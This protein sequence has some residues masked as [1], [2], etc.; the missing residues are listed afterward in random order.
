MAHPH[1]LLHSLPGAVLVICDNVLVQANPACLRLLE[2]DSVDQVVG[3]APE[4]FVHPPD[5]TRSVQRT[6]VLR[7]GV[8]DNQPTQMRVRTCKGALRQVLISSAAFRHEGRDAVLVNALDMSL[9]HDMQAQLRESERNFR[10]LFENMQDVYYRTNAEGVVVNVG[11]AVRRVLG[12]EPQDIIGRKAEAWYPN[13]ADRDAFKQAILAQGEVADFPGQMVRSDGRVIDI[14]ISSRALRDGDGQFAGVE[15]LWRD[16]TQRRQ[17]ERELRRMAHTDMLTGIA[18]RRAFLEQAEACLRRFRTEGR[19]FALLMLDLDHF[20]SVNDRFGHHEGDRVL[21]HFAEAVQSRI[22]GADMLG[23]LGGEE[24][25]LLLVRPDADAAE[26]AGQT[27]LRQVQELR[28]PGNGHGGPQGITTSIGMAGVQ[29]G[30]Q[31]VNDLLERADRALYQ[32][33]RQ[34]RNQLVRAA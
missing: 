2:A 24:F 6:S 7:P 3:H 33:K 29:P 10:A 20:K 8:A 18:N 21:V 13:A 28:L 1:D 16:V 26:A 14:S 11:P 27:V 23:R 25:G 5:L 4:D 32:A 12:V 30:D 22:S 9:Q 15:G 19:W 17:M 34:G 31:R